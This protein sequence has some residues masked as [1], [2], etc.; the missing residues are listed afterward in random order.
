MNI[1][2]ILA[3]LDLIDRLHGVWFAF[4]RA[5]W[6]G[7]FSRRGAVGLLTEMISAF[8]MH[9][10][11]VVRVSRMSSWSGLEIERM[12][13]RHGIRLGDFYIDSKEI[14]FRVELRQHTWALYV[15]RRAGVPVIMGGNESAATATAENYQAGDVPGNH[16]SWR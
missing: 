11:P 1:T 16:S 8:T 10:S 9:N 15:L 12:L 2:D 13:R 4:T 7:M 6:R 5:N 3:H 14:H